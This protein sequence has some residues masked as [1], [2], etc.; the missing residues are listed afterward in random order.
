MAMGLMAG[1]LFADEA[2][3]KAAALKLIGVENWSWHRGGFDAVMLADFT[4]TNAS[5]WAIKDITI[6]CRHHS[7]SGTAINE[8]TRTIYRTFPAHSEITVSD[9]NMGIIDSQA[10][11]SSASIEDLVFIQPHLSLEEI[12]KLEMA[13]AKSYQSNLVNAKLKAAVE[14]KH[15]AEMALKANESAAA[16]GDAYGLLRM[17]E[18]YRDG[19]GV[20]KD[21]AQARNFL[22][23]AALKGSDTAARELAALPQ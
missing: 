19:E 16:T 3:D 18:R 20:A 9:F 22:H 21:L 1:N 17:G 6:T 10:Q 14:K 8:N 13:A 23:Q 2:D 7:S 15:A 11:S 12:S 5:P 4:I